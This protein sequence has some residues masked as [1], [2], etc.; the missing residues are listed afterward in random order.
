MILLIMKQKGVF[1]MLNTLYSK[2]VNID[3]IGESYNPIKINDLLTGKGKLGQS[4]EKVLVIGID[5]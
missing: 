3:Y 1:K 5:Y 4:N 2:I